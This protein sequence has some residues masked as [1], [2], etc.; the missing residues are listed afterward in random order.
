M[1]DTEET[2]PSGA[3]ST[4]ATRPATRARATAGRTRSRSRAARAKADLAVEEGTLEDQVAELQ[5]ELRA[6]TRTLT[7]MGQSGAD[8]VRT[9]AQARAQEL[10][11][12]GQSMLAD[13][14]DEFGAFEKQIKDTIREKPLTAVAGAIAVGFLLAVITR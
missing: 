14:Q 6:V 13:A 12:R 3:N 11:D 4:R 2:A 7:R 5:N 10:A 1:A 9:T 8:G